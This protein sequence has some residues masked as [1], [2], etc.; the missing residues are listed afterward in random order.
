V[1]W[2]YDITGFPYY[3]TILKDEEIWSLYKLLPKKEFNTGSKGIEDTKDPN[4]VRILVIAKIILRDIY[5]LYSNILPD[6]KMI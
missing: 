6:W 2:L 3:L 4:L 5:R 1:P